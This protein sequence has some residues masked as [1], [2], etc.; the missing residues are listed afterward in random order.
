MRAMAFTRGLL[1]HRLMVLALVVASL[2]GGCLSPGSLTCSDGRV[3]PAGTSCDVHNHVCASV[4]AAA[5]CA[6][7]PDGDACSLSQVP[8]KCLAGIC[9]PFYCGDGHRNGTELC[10]QSDLG[11]Q[12]CASLHFYGQTTGLACKSDCSFDTSGCTGICG[13]A[14]KNGGEQ[15]DGADLGGAD[16]TTAG[17]YQSSG[18]ACSA[19]CTFDISGCSLYCGDSITNGPEACDGAPPRRNCLDYGFDRGILGCS[20]DCKPS[21]QGCDD[22]GWKTD[23]PI[24]SPLTGIW[25]S[26]PDDVYAING[27]DPTVLHWDGTTWSRIVPLVSHTVHFNGIWGSAANDI[28][29]VGETGSDQDGLVVHWDGANWTMTNLHSAAKGSFTPTAIWGRAKDDVHLVGLAGEIWHF[30]GQNWREV[31]PPPAP[32]TPTDGTTFLQAAAISQD[33]S[34][35][36][37]SA[38]DD[39]YAV[40]GGMIAHWN[41]STWSPTSVPYA[42]DYRGVW[43]SGRNDVFF[44]GAGG[45]IVHWD[46]ANWSSMISGTTNLLS[47]VWGTSARDVLA[48]GDGGTMLHWDGATWSAL[49]VGTQQPLR[50]V[51]GIRDRVFAVGGDP[52]GMALRWN[53]TSWQTVGIANALDPSLNAIWEAGPDDIFAVGDYGWIQRGGGGTWTPMLCNT[54]VP[55]TA[56]W[57]SGPD[58]VYAVG[59]DNP[60]QSIEGVICHWNGTDWTVLAEPLG[61]LGQRSAAYAVWGSGSDD[62][63]IVVV[64]G[65]LHWDGKAWSYT[66][67]A[68][69]NTSFFNSVWG[70]GRNDVY[71]TASYGG[72]GLLHWD[73]VTWSDATPPAPL[74]QWFNGIWGSARNDV[75]ANGTLGPTG[76]V[77]QT[78]RWDGTR[79]SV[80]DAYSGVPLAGSGRGDVFATSGAQIVHLRSDRWELIALPTMGTVHGL[81]VSPARV[82]VVG[83]MGMVQ[84]FR[85]S[86]TCVGPEQFCDDGWD[87]D[88]DGLADGADPDC[89]GKV[90]EQCANGADDDGDGKIDCADSDCASFPSCKKK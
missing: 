75:I 46:G 88:C 83:S 36:W 42:D 24:D 84:L 44:V 90:A 48:A 17:F 51:W 2:A 23:S 65:V 21:F 11:G 35:V 22:I 71:V 37:G 27:S 69:A 32:P 60:L 9:Q 73:G 85:D 8:G 39:V 59:Y 66:I 31:N 28:Y 74:P 6:G 72:G 55:L 57:G 79:W 4:A 1:R 61:L 53:R 64:D 82:D 26:A 18:L 34:D 80:V 52:G 86:V 12:T 45:A 56:V 33:L 70:S 78:I 77:A 40:G 25:G 38:A 76:G 19:S 62:V 50:A 7:H 58:D 14:T 13:D 5:A 16:C 67:K 10:D 41:G 29:F 49:D 47:R 30:D 54:Q 81:W 15:C 20:A 87:N 3:C 68:A 63:Y 89:A 43:G